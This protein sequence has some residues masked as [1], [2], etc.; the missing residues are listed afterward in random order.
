MLALEHS[1]DMRPTST[2]VSETWKIIFSCITLT[3]WILRLP[4]VTCYRPSLPHGSTGRW[5]TVF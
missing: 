2:R 4:K 1:A 3:I 5:W